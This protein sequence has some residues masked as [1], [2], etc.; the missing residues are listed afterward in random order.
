MAVQDVRWDKGGTELAD[1]YTKVIQKLLALSVTLHDS[2]Q[3]DSCYILH[4]QTWVSKTLLSS[5]NRGLHMCYTAYSFQ[6]SCILWQTS[7]KEIIIENI[8]MWWSSIWLR[9]SSEGKKPI[10]AEMA[11]SRVTMNS[12]YA[13]KA[14]V[15][16][17]DPSLRKDVWQLIN[18]SKWK[19]CV[20]QYI[21]Q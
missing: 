9:H 6:F 10:T 13:I 2:W 4:I 7:S 17:Q 8:G 1:H 16:L 21:M 19:V 18:C 14:V 20:T 5:G 15:C 11:D 3:L 12:L